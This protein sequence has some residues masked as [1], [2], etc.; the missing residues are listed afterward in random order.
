MPTTI[1]ALK[2]LLILIP[3]FYTLWIQECLGEKKER[4]LLDKL[5][6]ILMYNSGGDKT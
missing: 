1:I 4:T 6:I 5:L 2:I 3:G